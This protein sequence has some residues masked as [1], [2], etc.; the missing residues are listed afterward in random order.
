[1]ATRQAKF[2]DPKDG[3][4]MDVTEQ[5]ARSAQIRSGQMINAERDAGKKRQNWTSA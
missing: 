2:D 4:G 5:R 1:M 3:E